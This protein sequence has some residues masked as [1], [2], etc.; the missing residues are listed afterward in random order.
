[1]MAMISFT[2]GLPETG[3]RG[4]GQGYPHGSHGHKD[5]TGRMP[6]AVGACPGLGEFRR[7]THPSRVGASFRTRSRGGGHRSTVATKVGPPGC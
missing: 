3:E 5:A 4:V 1:M 7:S 6:H 2:A